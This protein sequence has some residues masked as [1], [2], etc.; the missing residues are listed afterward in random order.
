[1]TELVDA[2]SARPARRDSDLSR[3]VL[4]DL[5]SALWRAVRPTQWVKNA[6]VLAAPGAAGVLFHPQVLV[7]CALAAVAITAVASGCYLINDVR[8]RELDRAHPRKRLRPVASGEL[9]VRLALTGA[10][11]LM[12]TG[13]LVAAAGPPLLVA[14]VASYAM[15]TLSYSAGVKHSTV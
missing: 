1:M 6:L 7:G 4:R 15:L 11:V 3:P 5:P 2:G 10:T 14:L 13:L 8:D 9:P 12:L